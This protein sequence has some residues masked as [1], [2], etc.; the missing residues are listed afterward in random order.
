MSSCAGHICTVQFFLCKCSLQQNGVGR[1]LCTIISGCLASLALDLQ[2]WVIHG[3]L[4]QPQVCM[5]RGF[6]ILITCLS[7]QDSPLA[8]HPALAT[9]HEQSHAHSRACFVGCSCSH[10]MLVSSQD[11][12]FQVKRNHAWP[13]QC[14]LRLSEF[15]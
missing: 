11:G 14:M 13:T 8:L 6:Y 5:C 2:P 1:L 10:P 15:C 7:L 3:R 4:T 9:A 12:Y